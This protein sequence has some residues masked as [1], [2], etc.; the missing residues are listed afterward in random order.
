MAEHDAAPFDP[1]EFATVAEAVEAVLDF[2]RARPPAS[3]EV[4]ARYYRARRW[5]AAAVAY[6]QER[7][8][9]EH[10]M[11]TLRALIAEGA[12]YDRQAATYDDVFAYEAG[13]ANGL[14]ST[15]GVPGEDREF[16]LVAFH[17]LALAMNADR[18]QEARA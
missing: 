6:A 10:P 12:N 4:L 2:G 11:M 15:A 13:V 14:L 5:L 9:P 16:E 3:D 17:A 7:G 18:A 8:W 1:Q